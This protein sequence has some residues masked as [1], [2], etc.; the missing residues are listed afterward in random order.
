MATPLKYLYNEAF[1]EKFLINIKAIDP[2]IEGKDLLQCIQ[3]YPWEELELK[4]RMRHITT[5]LGTVLAGRTYAQQID[6]LLRLLREVQTNGVEEHTIEYLFLPDFVAYYGIDD[7]ELS[8]AALEEITVF[9]SAEFAVRPFIMKYPTVM[10]QQMEEWSKHKAPMVR[11]LSSEGFRPRL[12]WG[13]ALPALKKDPTPLLSM[14]N[15]LKGDPSESVRRSVANNLNDISKDHPELVVKIAHD[16]YGYQKEIDWVVKHACRTLLKAGNQSLMQLFGFGAIDQILVE[17]VQIDTPTVE[18]GDYL[19]FQFELKN[20]ATIALK[21]RLEYA[22][23]YHKANGTLSRKVFKI[24]EKEYAP[25][26]ATRVE[27]RQSFKIISTRKYHAG[28]HQVALVINGNELER[29][30]FDVTN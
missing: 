3:Q 18:V 19:V 30:E 9:V 8:I 6:F 15:R 20:L 10:Q 27:R 24:S 29:L 11:R 28:L 2:D 23:Y 7:Y 25:H 22:I 5:S 13:A 16:W 4:Q 12:P 17:N 21:I 26:S 1:F 14:L